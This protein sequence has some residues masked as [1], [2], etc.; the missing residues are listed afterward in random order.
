MEECFRWYGPG[1]PVPLAHIRH[2]GATGIVT[3]L[4]AVYDGSP[5]PIDQLAALKAGIEAEGLTWSV[6]ESIPV[7]NQIKIAGPERD[8]YIGYYKDS[9]RALAQVGLKTICY[10][11]MPVVDW[12]RTELRHPM[13]N[14]ALALRFDAVDFAAYDAFVLKRPGA[15][16]DY[17]AA[18][19][20]E[21]KAR[22]ALRGPEG[23]A[24][25]EHTLIAGL[26][27]AERNYDR[28]GFLAALS[29]YRDIS[30]ADL[31]DN[32]THFLRQIGPV[33]EELGQRLC[34]HPDDPAFSLFGLPRVVSTADDARRILAAY[35]SPANGLTFCTGSYGTR[36][37]NDLPAMVREFGP[38]IHFAHLRNVTR[39]ADGSFHEADHLGGSTDMPAVILA[40]LDEQERRRAEGRADWQIPLRP[41]HGHLLADDIAKDRINPGYSL[42]GRLRGLAELRGT[43]AG[44]AAARK[45]QGEPA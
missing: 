37:D 5:W 45:H 41:D 26:P 34:I 2:A 24:R 36:A 31:Q 44:I 14:G 19:L 11:F 7:H 29:E 9:M 1:D 18:R 8:R 20:T 28:A 43:M 16:G 38:R 39:E 10:N 21:A 4:H 25:V 33:A 35:D 40:L 3:A 32:L 12:T 22:L 23:M 42:I 27:A 6:V 17:T 15:E 30:A 13:P